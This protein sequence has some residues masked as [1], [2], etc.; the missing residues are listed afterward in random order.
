MT[1]GALLAGLIICV[2]AQHAAAQQPRTAR[3]SLRAELS[4]MNDSLVSAFR[5]GNAAAVARFYADD[6]RM[7]GERGEV[8]EG[9]ESIDRFWANVK[10]PKS[11][12]LDVIAIGGRPDQPYE[13][14]RST[15]VTSG[16]NGDRVSV[17]EYL[18]IFRRDARGKLRII[19]DYYRY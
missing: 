10:N 3:R 9:R 6:A 14:G 13:I 2:G 16:P 4:A 1:R 12:K 19:V 18:L 17:V 11:W 15:I 8:V 7:D 5:G